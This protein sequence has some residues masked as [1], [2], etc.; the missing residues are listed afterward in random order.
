MNE[1]EFNKSAIPTNIKFGKSTIINKI[2]SNESI[3]NA[4]KIFNRGFK[5]SLSFVKSNAVS[6]SEFESLYL[7][8][9][10]IYR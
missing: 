1:I 2:K 8:L 7:F 10:K 9:F 4:L 6:S 3:S 5:K